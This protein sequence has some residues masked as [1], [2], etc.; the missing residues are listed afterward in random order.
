MDD[1]QGQLLSEYAWSL[2]GKSESTLEA[3]LRVLRQFSGWVADRP[4]SNGSCRPEQLTRTAV[5]TYLAHLEAEGYS[6]SHRARVKS[7]VSGFARWLI[8]EKG[9]LLRNPTRGVDIPA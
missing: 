7:A 3:Y 2:S 8:E 4:G 5:E 6:V 9:V 1:A